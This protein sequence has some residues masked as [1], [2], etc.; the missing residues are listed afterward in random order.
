MHASSTKFPIIANRYPSVRH[1]MTV[2]KKEK[3]EP[4]MHCNDPKK[5]AK[6]ERRCHVHP[7]DLEPPNSVVCYLPRSRD[8][9]ET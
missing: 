3:R 8:S 5:P 9:G 7:S 6:K 2:V 4:A 1:A